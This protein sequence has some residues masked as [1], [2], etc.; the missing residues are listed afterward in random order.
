[1]RGETL[2]VLGSAI[3]CGVLVF[4]LAASPLHGQGDL[5]D[6]SVSVVP[7]PR[8]RKDS[9]ARVTRVALEGRSL[10]LEI[11]NTGSSPIS[12]LTVLYESS[13]CSDVNVYLWATDSRLP[14]RGWLL[15]R[16]L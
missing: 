16:L 7:Q 2:K 5:P 10:R 15:L 1:M 14:Q 6:A 12:A 11:E 8:P 4:A 9:V 3:E 13:S